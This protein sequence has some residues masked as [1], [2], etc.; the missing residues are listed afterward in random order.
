MKTIHHVVD[1]DAVPETV[2]T[3]ITERDR[4][5]AWWSTGVT[6]PPA[7]V[8]ARIDWTFGGDFNPVMEIS[9]LVPQRRLVW[10]C[11]SG[12]DNW[13]DNDFVFELVRKYVEN[14]E[15]RKMAKMAA[16][17]SPRAEDSA[18]GVPAPAKATTG[19]RQKVTMRRTVHRLRD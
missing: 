16:Q 10:R 6:S 17:A 8:G 7:Q 4:L 14:R 12:H 13:K 5:A 11:V 18:S 9:E 1:V 15:N 19:H 2:W 3:A